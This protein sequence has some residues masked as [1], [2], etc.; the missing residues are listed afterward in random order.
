MARS[1]LPHFRGATVNP[2][3]DLGDKA[4]HLFKVLVEEYLEQGQPVSSNTIASK[5]PY[6]VSS[7]TV[8]NNMAKLQEHGLVSSPHTSA[9]RIPTQH[10]LRFF[11]DGL[12]S[13]EPLD[14]EAEQHVWDE[15]SRDQSR[16][17]LLETASQM[18]SDFTHL[19]GLVSMPREEQISLRQVEFLPLTGR[20]VLAVLIVNEREV[21]NRVIETSRPYSEV[22]LKQAANFINDSFGGRSLEA[23]RKGVLDSMSRD[24]EQINEVLQRAYDI[25]SRTF[26]ESEHDFVVAGER[27]LVPFTTSGEK[28]QQ[29][30][31]AF[32]SKSSIVHLLD[33][34]ID[35]EGVRLFIGEESGYE[36]FEDYSLIT[37]PYEVKGK[38]AGVLGVIGPTRMSYQKVVPFVDV[39]SRV[40]GHVIENS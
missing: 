33:A 30:L 3:P 38:V 22:E 7:A 28:V 25:A 2:H 20:Q 5:S 40:L 10:G 26:I 4:A 13:Y 27:H 37:A 21:Q 8:R 34:C 6:T 12:I 14:H 23:I 1:T 9:G 17:D 18:L 36:A 11:V 19:A 39:T 29:L 15:L 32:E 35:G 31:E 24:K 16:Q